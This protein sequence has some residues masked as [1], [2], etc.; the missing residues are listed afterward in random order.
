MNASVNP[1]QSRKRSRIKII[2][3]SALVAFGLI[4][5]SA[6]A[7]YY[8]VGKYHEGQLES[9]DASVQGPVAMPSVESELPE[10][11]GV[12]LPDG[13]FKPIHSVVKSLEA[14]V[15]DRSFETQAPVRPAPPPDGSV[16]DA[17]V[18]P[19]P[20]DAPSIEA[21]AAADAIGQE[22]PTTEP[23]DG[24]KLIYSYNAIYPGY[25]MHPKYWGRPSTAGSDDYTF[26]VV[27]RPDG[28]VTLVPSQGAPRGKA[29][30]ASAIRIPSIGVDSR[31]ED[32]A[33]VELGD[34]RQYETPKHIVG[35]I[36]STSNPG[37]I[38]NSW[39]F[40]H[41]ESPIRGEGN[42]FQRLPEIPSLLN[43]GDPVYVSLLND[44]GDEF[45]YQVTATE[46][47]H[48]DELQL[49]ETDDATI[50]LVACVPKLV[51]DRRLLVTGKLVG[52]KRAA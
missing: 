11:H 1:D 51:Y 32:L 14:Y 33:I 45:L 3:G 12:L 2:A 38:G 48:Q 25:Q 24:G 9:L 7:T 30:E 31:V 13:S 34:S 36:P 49:Y 27:K 40:G 37:E 22:N 18:D 17:V 29:S 47:V 4:A 19:P 43:T 10:I 5:I 20:D 15:D 42:V 41:L 46:V 44:E 39:L 26:G 28:F 16:E 21:A 52:V 50:T 35:R 8:F 23:L 6:V